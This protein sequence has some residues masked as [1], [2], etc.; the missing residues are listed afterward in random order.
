MRRFI[1]GLISFAS[2]CAAAQ[3][4]QEFVTQQ[5]DI[6]ALKGGL[7]GGMAAYA[8][9]PATPLFALQADTRLT[10]ASTLKLL[11]TAAAL[12][13]FGPQHRFQTRL[14]AT[15][16]PDANGVLRGD[17]YLRGGGDPTLGSTRVT[18]AETMQAVLNKWQQAIEAAGIKQISG[19][20]YA[21]VSLFD[22][23]T[24]APKVNWENMGNYYAAPSSPLN[25]N[26]NLFEIYFAPQ[27]KDG[28]SVTVSR[29]EP[30]VEGLAL[31][32][33]VTADAKNHKDNA[34]VYGAPGQYQ[35][36][37]FGTIPA[38]SKEFKIKGALPDPA[39]FTVQALRKQLTEHDIRVKGSAKTTAQAPDYDSMKLLHT[40]YSPALKDI[41]VIVNKRSFNLY[42]EILLRNLAVAAGKKGSLQNGLNE[43]IVFLRKRNLAGANDTVLYDGSGL[44]RDNLITPRTLLNVLAYMAQSP[45]FSDYYNSLATPDDR[46]DLLLLRRFLKPQKKVNEVRIKGGTIDSVKAGAG[47]TRDKNGRLIAFVLMANNLAG[48]DEELFRAHE[49][50]IKKLLELE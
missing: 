6:A 9:T 16:A 27:P 47:Y 2:T 3:P 29:T 45:Y 28:Q 40:Y 15:A 22:G 19:N 41:V 20:I 25:F 31:Q 8:Q 5:T 46:G 50:I 7:W 49:E 10:P 1:L 4:L 43:L 11:T 38:T 42:A 18:G 33:F 21:D 32:S 13:I 24:V 30:T 44:S 48:K 14:Y 23:P 39:L 36:K 26:D 12:E 34:Y 37:I 35:L 17:I